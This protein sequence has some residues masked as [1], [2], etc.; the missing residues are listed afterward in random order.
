VADLRARAVTPHIAINGAVSKMG[1]ARK[2]AIDRRT[3]SRL[4]YAISQRIRK[5]IEEGFEWIKIQAG[6]AKTKLR[7]TPK[8]GAA[9]TLAITACNLIRIPKLVAG[10]R[11]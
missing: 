9:F 4:G 8:G 6:M 11:T 1:K 10:A 7:G 3:T 5:R 2:T